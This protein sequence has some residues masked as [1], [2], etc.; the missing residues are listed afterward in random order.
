VDAAWSALGVGCEWFSFIN[1][2]L[3]TMTL[4]RSIV[5]PVEEA[6]RTGLRHDQVKVSQKY[7][8]GF[9]ANVEG[10]HHLHCLVRIEPVCW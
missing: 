5:V 1:T 4:D 9:P 10:L 8:G 7:G 6:E 2:P 3:L